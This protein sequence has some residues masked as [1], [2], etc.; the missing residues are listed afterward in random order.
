MRLVNGYWYWERKQNK[1]KVAWSW[2]DLSKAFSEMSH[3]QIPA[4]RRG[5]LQTFIEPWARCHH[6][7]PSEHEEGVW[8][9][10]V[11]PACWVALLAA[12]CCRWKEWDCVERFKNPKGNRNLWDSIEICVL[13]CHII[14]PCTAKYITL[15]IKRIMSK[16]DIVNLKENGVSVEHRQLQK[17]FSNFL[18]HVKVMLA[19]VE[20][21]LSG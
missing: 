18:F 13:F 8:V 21:G 12:G 4:R 7:V 16:H 6:S 9:G 14:Q 19:S 2:W 5:N 10:T 11:C 3:L 17:S 1:Q 20:Y 15:C